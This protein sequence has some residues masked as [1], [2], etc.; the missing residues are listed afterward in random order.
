[1]FDILSIF[2]IHIIENIKIFVYNEKTISFK[3]I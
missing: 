1:M 2:E 3:Q